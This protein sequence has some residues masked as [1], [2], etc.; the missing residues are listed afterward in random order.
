MTSSPCDITLYLPGLLGP[1][2]VYPQLTHADKPDLKQLESL[3]SRADRKAGPGTDWLAGLFTLF[4]LS[5]DE[6]ACPVAAVTAAYDGLDA[7]KGWW[8]RADPVY[9]QPDRSQAVL[10]ASD[11]LQL[12]A[13][14]CEGLLQTLNQHF[15]EDGWQFTAPHPQRW[16]LR[17]DNAE[18]ITTT[19]LHEVMGQ[20]V[21]E[22]LPSG[23]KQRDWHTR[24][25]ELQML[26]HNH[27]VN[28]KRVAAGKMPVNSVWFWG[29]G[30]M[31]KVNATPWDR[32]FSDNDVV[33]ALAQLSKVECS[34]LADFDANTLQGRN[35]VV[36]A[37]CY[38]TVQSRDVFRWLECLQSVQTQ[39]LLP[40]QAGLKRGT[41]NSMKLLPVN[42]HAYQLS[43]K[44]LRRWWQ[45]RRS[46]ETFLT[47]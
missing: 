14:E 8:L 11:A 1:Q 19:P 22:H 9:L 3:L 5:A 6:T 23:E 39:Y 4:D 2:S 43:R 46:L 21:H 44:Q 35:L 29:Q 13:D 16:Y 20:S 33:R 27:E 34:C 12:Q 10:V 42:G 26:L 17:L 15:A 38:A 37:D 47:P 24:L 25:N 36:M 30:T 32:V 31:P 45:R 40:L 7:S 41:I 28:D 18:S